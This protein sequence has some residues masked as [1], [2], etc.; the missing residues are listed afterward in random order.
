MLGGILAGLTTCALWGLTF[1]A[2]RAVDPFSTWDLTVARYGI[3][4]AA[5]VLFM[6]HPRFRPTGIAVHRLVIG[7]LLG[8]CYVAFFIGASYGVTLAGAAIPP[9]VIGTMPVLLAII[10]NWRDRSVPWRSLLFPM[11]LIVVGMLVV[12]VAVLQASNVHDRTAVILGTFA[13]AGALL[14]WITYGYVNAA[15]MRALDA[16][17][18]LRWTGVQG[19]GAALA[20]MLLLPLVSFG[21]GSRISQAAFANFALWALLLGL[22]GSWLATFFWVIASQ[23]LPLALAAQLIVAE[24]IF[25]LLYG[26]LFEGRWP[27]TA[28]WMG[29]SIQIA[30]VAAAIAVF[31][32]SRLPKMN[33]KRRRRFHS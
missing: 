18:S 12:N 15:V 30:G 6:L 25:G 32:R 11:L 28:E 3:F 8:A 19:M 31:T 33:G 29:A 14:V 2:P 16:P 22:A 23:R 20:S 10:G 9:L 26:F 5:S 24:T 13:S 1:V 4:G 7:L 27:T 21:D 17:D